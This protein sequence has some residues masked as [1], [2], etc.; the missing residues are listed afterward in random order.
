M[1]AIE[2]VVYKAMATTGSSKS[3]E[4][5]RVSA[6]KHADI[7][8]KNKQIGLD[9][10]GNASFGR[11]SENEICREEFFK[12]FAT[13]L[14]E[15]AVKTNGVLLMSGTAMQYLSALK[16]YAQAKFS[17]NPLWIEKSL[18]TWYPYL[19]LAIES[20]IQHRQIVNGLPIA[21]SSQAIGRNLLI[22][23]SESL[24]ITGSAEAMKRRLAIVMTFH[25]IGR[26]G[27]SALSTWTSAIW[28]RQLGNLMINWNEK[29]TCASNHEPDCLLT[30]SL[31]LSLTNSLFKWYRRI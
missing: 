26:S 4:A 14:A 1:A 5:G 20:N 29:K 11:L 6:L 2:P 21:E 23:I 27:E 3:T 19:R 22:S 25:A 8:C 31:T 13:Y 18:D 17:S 15:H 7:F 24:M 16:E 30:N 12:E 9:N 10:R 28:D